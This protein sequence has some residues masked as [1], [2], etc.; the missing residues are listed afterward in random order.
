MKVE[1]ITSGAI[2]CQILT[3]M[4]VTKSVL[5]K[6]A[7]AWPTKEQGGLFKN[8]WANIVGGWCVNHYLKYNKPPR[9]SISAIFHSWAEGGSDDESQG[10]PD[11]TTIEL[12]ESFLTGLSKRNEGKKT[13]SDPKFVVDLANKH[14][15]EV[16]LTRHAESILAD[17]QRGKMKRASRNAH[18]FKGIDIS[19]DAVISVLSS[20]DTLKKALESSSI[21]NSLITFEKAGTAA[22]DFFRGVFVPDSFVSFFGATGVGKSY[23]LMKVVIEM[24]KEGHPVLY[25]VTGDMSPEQVYARIYT[26]ILGRPLKKDKYFYPASIACTG[27]DCDVKREMREYKKAI[28]YKDAV[29]LVK[30]FLKTD[31]SNQGDIFRM[32]TYPGRSINSISIMHKAED[33]IRQGFYPK[34]ICV[35]Y[36][37]EFS[38]EPGFTITDDRMNI[39]AA[40]SYLRSIGQRIKCNVSVVTQADADS[41]DAVLLSRKNFTDS[42][43]KLDKVT[44]MLGI[45]QTP[46]EK[47]QGIYRINFLK[48]RTGAYSQQTCLHVASCLE[49]ADPMI[50]SSIP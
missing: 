32:G 22:A 35:D 14:F 9:K 45:N 30:E 6:V 4:I 1:K 23:F 41:Y 28:R 46:Y 8:K 16:S 5:A 49:I 48:H 29:K 31:L 40:W 11:S 25:V 42:R 34:S 43:K 10:R 12:I 36:P 13:A 33:E 20:P 19:S 39:N 37:D 47:E 50:D 24:I 2:E 3:E 21:D 44:V 7:P 17:I 26:M 27:D 15:S 38:P 18:G